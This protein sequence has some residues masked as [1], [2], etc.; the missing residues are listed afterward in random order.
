MGTISPGGINIIDDAFKKLKIKKGCDVLDI[1]CGNG[2]TLSL[3]KEKYEINAVGIDKSTAL[4]EQ[5][6]EKYK[7]LDL[8]EGEADFL[9]FSSLNFDVVIMECVLS[10]LEMK[11]ESIHE[12]FCML[13]PKGKL[14]I[15]DLFGKDEG[16]LNKEEIISECEELGFSVIEEEDRTKDLAIFSA[17]KI[18]EYGSIKAY[19]DAITPEGDDKESFCKAAGNS[20]NVKY[21]VLILEKGNSDASK[22]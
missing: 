13:R 8:Q 17:E 19:F 16:M 7:D 11:V 21:L 9:S 20:K 2:S 14:I 1:G 12:A 18:M 10:V 6:K 15:T 5:G 22:N 3:L 4:I